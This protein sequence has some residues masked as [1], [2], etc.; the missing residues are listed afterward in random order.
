MSVIAIYCIGYIFPNHAVLINISSGRCR[1]L[2]AANVQVAAARSA[3]D[4]ADLSASIENGV[5]KIVEKGIEMK[6]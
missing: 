5:S 3:L 6:A 1:I 4:N 2:A